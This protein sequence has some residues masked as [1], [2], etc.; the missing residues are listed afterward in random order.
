MGSSA[1]PYGIGIVRLDRLGAALDAGDAV[2]AGDAAVNV[3]LPHW[4]T[5]AMPPSSGSSA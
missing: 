4:A 1:G 2:L 5:Y 3:A